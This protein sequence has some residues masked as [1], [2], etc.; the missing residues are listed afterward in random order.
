MPLLRPALFALALVTPTTVTAQNAIV[1]AAI[2]E[3]I[4]PRYETLVSSTAALAETAQAECEPNSED[5]R[6]A[7]HAATDAWMGV[8]HLRF[9]PSE[10]DNRAFALAFW[11]DTRGFTPRSLATL[12]TDQDPIG[13][14]A[15]A[16]TE[17]T[18][19][20]RGFYALE[21]LLYDE[22]TSSLEPADYRCALTQTVTADIAATSVAILSDWQDRFADILSTPSPDNP[23]YRSEEES[24]RALF[25]ALSTGLE[26]AADQ[27]L[28][29]PMGTFERPRPNRAEMRRSERSLRNV[30]LSLEAL[31]ELAAIMA[32]EDAELAEE[33]AARLEDSLAAGERLDDP[34]F[35]GVAEPLGRIRVEALR[36]QVQGLRQV[37]GTGLG[38]AL[39][40][41]AG[42]NSLDGD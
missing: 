29:R 8:S 10:E 22:T 34:A 26:F 36:N 4:L 28:A 14:D 23:L 12:V 39:G 35:A 38:P 42:F 1:D 19:A 11:P 9:G 21:F 31:G 13:L 37:V 16:Y 40:V 6:T 30:M 24:L 17:V 5:L 33:L 25:G 7:Y 27:R 32:G 18:V 2:S 15:E 20:A 3:H 41:G